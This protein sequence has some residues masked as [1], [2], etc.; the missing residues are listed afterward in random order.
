MVCPHAI[1]A[2]A[3][4]VGPTLTFFRDSDLQGV[5]VPYLN[6]KMPQRALMLLDALKEGRMNTGDETSGSSRRVCSFAEVKSAA[7]EL[8][9]DNKPE[10]IRYFLKIFS[11]LGLLTWFPKLDRNLVVLDPQW[12]IDSMACLIRE[13]AGKHSQLL[14]ALQFD[15]LAVTLFN[16]DHARAGFLAVKLMHYIWKSNPMRSKG[17]NESCRS[18][19]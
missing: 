1:T 10:D 11:G 5:R 2:Q 13:H 8:K 16:K 4:C 17:S 6:F 18:S 14:E 7:A 15:P 19:V 3:L 12:L 9:L